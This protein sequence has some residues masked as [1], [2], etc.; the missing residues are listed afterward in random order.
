[1]YRESQLAFGWPEQKCKEWD[2]LAKKD[3]TYKLTPE[4]KRRYK[5]QWYLTLNKGHFHRQHLVSVK[6]AELAFLRRLAD[7]AASRAATVAMAV[8]QS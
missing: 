1:M 4:E 6:R 2:E 5:G 7:V 3:H 8:R